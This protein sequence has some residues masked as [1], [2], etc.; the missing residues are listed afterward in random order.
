M[1]ILIRLSYGKPVKMQS[2][3]FITTILYIS[4]AGSYCCFQPSLYMHKTTNLH[5]KN[6]SRAAS[7]ICIAGFSKKLTC[8]PAFS[9]IL[10]TNLRKEKTLQEK[11]QI[12]FNDGVDVS[13][14]ERFVAY[15]KIVMPNEREE[16]TILFSGRKLCVKK[17][18]LSKPGKTNTLI[19]VNIAAN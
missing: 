4:A 12:L 14:F 17:K 6:N 3:S 7:G 16:A 2:V 1:A 9:H 5:S 19:P 13:V 8:R 18:R 15:D 11:F 10:T